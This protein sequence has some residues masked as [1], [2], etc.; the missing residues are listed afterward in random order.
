MRPVEW[1][2]IIIGMD[3][4]HI[5]EVDITKGFVESKTI[6]LAFG[7]RYEFECSEERVAFEE[8]ISQFHKSC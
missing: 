5:L 1:M 3:P 6:R 8:C 4:Q 2:H 7:R